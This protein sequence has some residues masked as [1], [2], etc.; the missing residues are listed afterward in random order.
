MYLIW[1]FYFFLNLIYIF[2]SLVDII[3]P[4]PLPRNVIN[5]N[6]THAINSNSSNNSTS[7]NANELNNSTNNKLATATITPTAVPATVTAPTTN[8]TTTTPSTNI[9][10]TTKNVNHTS[11]PATVI[12]ST[13]S[14]TE[15]L[16]Q[17]FSMNNSKSQPDVLKR[18]SSKKIASIF[19]VRIHISIEL[20]FKCASKWLLSSANFTAHLNVLID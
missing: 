12:P 10:T 14:K 11:T 19:E 20:Y 13:V 16:I 18:I 4:K 9:T 1:N 15:S 7:T 3:K 5:G 6:F 2:L 17:R 8:T